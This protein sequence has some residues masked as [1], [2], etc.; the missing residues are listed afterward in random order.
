MTFDPRDNSSTPS[1]QAHDTAAPRNLIQFMLKDW[2]SPT[3]P[4]PRPAKNAAQH[5]ARRTALSKLF[6]GETLVIPTGRRKVRANDT[7]YPFRPGSDFFYLTGCWEPDCVLI[8]EPTSSGH[9]AL[10]FV[11]PNLGKADPSFFTDRVKGELWEGPRPTVEAA[12]ALYGIAA[13]SGLPALGATLKR[14]IVPGSRWRAL[15]GHD[16]TLE[17]QLSAPGPHQWTRDQELTTAL[18]EMRLHKDAAEVK[19]LQ[20]AIDATLKGFEDVIR[21]L[22]TAKSERE[23]EGVFW[24]RARME[25]NDVGYGSI[26]ASGEHACTLHWK[27][28]DGH[29]RKGDLLLLDA[30]IEGHSLY[31]ADITRTMPVSGRFT[32]DQKTIYELVLAAQEVAMKQVKPG[33]DFMAPNTAAMAV[34]AHGLE[35]LGILKC[36][37]EE[38][39][40]E[41]NQFYKRYTLHNVSHMLGIDVHDCAAARAEAYKFGQLKPGM[42]L[43]VEPGLYFQPDDLTV[44]ARYRGIGVRIEDNVLVTASGCKVLSARIPKKTA[45]LERWMKRLWA[46]R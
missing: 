1:R 26:V 44:P 3:G 11:E 9:D 16:A 37:A 45:E 35:K 31:T 17:S 22:K 15:R 12:A 36:S 2:K 4:Q 46:K 38:A 39:L 20:A 27:K 10:L 33:N 29:I 30:G 21:R 13:T 32:K 42:V 23:L 6:P 24:T 34:L 40:K 19:E 14:L 7:H 41:E 43:T 8:L 28:N 5:E 18:S 25:G